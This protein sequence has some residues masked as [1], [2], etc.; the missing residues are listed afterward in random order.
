LEGSELEKFGL[1][2]VH[3]EEI[4]AIWYIL[5]PLGNLASIGMVYFPPFGY[6]YCVEHTN[7]GIVEIF[8]TYETAFKVKGVTGGYLLKCAFL[9][10]YVLIDY[11]EIVF[12]L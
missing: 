2:Y 4:K 7:R 5:W 10:T 12:L 1:V 6:M 11:S 3:S 9:S 8:N